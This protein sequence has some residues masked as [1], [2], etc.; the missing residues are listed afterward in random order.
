[1]STIGPHLD[2]GTQAD[3]ITKITVTT[4]L[5]HSCCQNVSN[6]I[7][8]LKKQNKLAS[9]DVCKLQ[10]LIIINNTSECVFPPRSM[11]LEEQD[12]SYRHE[13]H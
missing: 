8:N 11:F 2:H 13:I 6:V 4:D 5:I 3:S 1:M 7:S 12:K 10:N 9:E